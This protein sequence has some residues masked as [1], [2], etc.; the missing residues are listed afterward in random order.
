[1]SKKV[2]IDR[3]LGD[4]YPENMRITSDGNLIDLDGWNIYLVYNEAPQSGSSKKVRLHGI[5]RDVRKG[6]A[7]FYP[8]VKYSEDITDMNNIV[9]YEAFTIPGSFK[10]DLFRSKDVYYTDDNGEY[11]IIVNAYVLYDSLEPT[12][13]GLQRYLKYT[14]VQ[15]HY[16]GLINIIDPLAGS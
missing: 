16:N 8:R 1:M 15:H 6:F 10:Y 11:V 12:H 2:N 13:A 9:N 7:S 5:I 3:I 4:T 14:E